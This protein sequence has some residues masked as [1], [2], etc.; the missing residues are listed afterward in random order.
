MRVLYITNMYPTSENSAFG[1]FVK[2]QI[3]SLRALGIDGDVFLIKG[4][5]RRS[6]Y[7]TSIIHIGSV[8]MG[9]K[10]D[11]VHVYFGYTGMVVLLTKWLFGRKQPT[12]VTFLGSDILGKVVE[13]K[14]RKKTK[15]GLSLICRESAR[16]F[17]QVI[18]VSSEMKRLLVRTKNKNIEVIPLGANLELFRLL[19]K[20]ESREKLCLSKNK[21]IVLFGGDSNVP[22]KNYA[23]AKEAF[24]FVKRKYPD[25]ELLVLKG[26]RR[27]KVALLMNAV[28]VLLLPSIHEGSPMVIREAMACGLPIVSAN[29]GDVKGLIDNTNGCY[30][31]GY[32]PKDIAGKILKA[33][34][35]K[36]KTRGRERLLQLGLDQRQVAKKIIEVYESILKDRSLN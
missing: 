3:N 23:L 8:L 19:G 25:V 32:A 7:L 16:F 10:Y 21:K 24:E 35:F 9:K 13:S 27:E 31:C 5:L 34:D 4:R 2:E 33:L 17:D 22:R 29:V 36:G 28:D 15:R 18:V 1:I 14:G 26:R 6:K 20:Q 30:I 12:V 11:L